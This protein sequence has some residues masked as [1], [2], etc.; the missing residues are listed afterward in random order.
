MDFFS[1]VGITGVPAAHYPM[2]NT[3]IV[4]GKWIPMSN[5]MYTFELRVPELTILRTEV[6]EEDAMAEKND[7]AGLLACLRDK[8]RNPSSSTL[9]PQGGEM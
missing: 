3:K 2:K 4:A 8:A 5:Q 9:Q 6:H 1:K 7:F